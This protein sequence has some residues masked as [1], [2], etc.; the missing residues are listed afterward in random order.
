[1]S[2][3][4]LRLEGKRLQRL[5]IWKTSAPVDNYYVHNISAT[6]ANRK[7]IQEMIYQWEQTHYAGLSIS[8]YL[9]RM[10]PEWHMTVCLREECFTPYSCKV[11]KI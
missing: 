11:E 10:I 5:Y 2:H 9:E 1:M 4:N 8:E 3:I 7:L 6:Q